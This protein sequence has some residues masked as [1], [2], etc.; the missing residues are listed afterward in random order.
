MTLIASFADQTLPALASTAVADIHDR[1]RAC[2]E[3]LA[4]AVCQDGRVIGAIE[5]DAVAKAMMAGFAQSAISALVLADP[6]IVDAS[7]PADEVCRALLANRD[8]RRDVFVVV[9]DGAYLGVG[10]LGGLVERLLQDRSPQVRGIEQAVKA[11]DRKSTRLNSSHPLKS[12][13][14]SSA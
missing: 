1:F 12:R 4:F 9:K 3:A 11:V 8:L 5:R 10:S 14:P 13:M 7:A 2:P 6:L